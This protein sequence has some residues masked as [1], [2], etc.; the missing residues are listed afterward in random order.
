MASM[1]LLLPEPFGP[2]RERERP[3]QVD[4]GIFESLEISKVM[5]C[6]HL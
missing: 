5:H 4:L 6:G 3:Q 2:I 1:T